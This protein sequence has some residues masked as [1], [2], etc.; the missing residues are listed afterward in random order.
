M[1][2]CT[3][4]CDLMMLFI[5][6]QELG[7][8]LCTMKASAGPLLEQLVL[9]GGDAAAIALAAI[10]QTTCGDSGKQAAVDAFW[11]STALWNMGDL[12]RCALRLLGGA[13]RQ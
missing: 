10:T 1:E 6:L 12:M 11:N 9:A 7:N 4:M 2:A 8:K 3:L 13:G 5:G